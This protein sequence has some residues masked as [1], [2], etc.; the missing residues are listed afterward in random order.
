M[1]RPKVHLQGTFQVR[2]ATE[3]ELF[4]IY[5]DGKITVAMD[6]KDAKRLI[7][8]WVKKHMSHTKI[9]VAT[10]DWFDGVKPPV[11]S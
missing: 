4:V 2:A 6:P 1:S 8:K 9:N 11:D 7:D 10:I 3:G 5:P